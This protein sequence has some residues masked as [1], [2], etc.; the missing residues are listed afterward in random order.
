MSVFPSHPPSQLKYKLAL[1]KL[2]KHHTKRISL[3]RACFMLCCGLSLSLLSTL[4]Y[5]QVKEQSQIKI[6]GGKLIN[7]NNIY[8]TLNFDYPQFIWGING[9]K[10]EQKIES[11]P[12]VAVA[13]VNRK[14]IPPEIVISLQE[15]NPVALASFQGQV[16]FLDSQGEWISLNFYGNLDLDNALPR[17]KVID[18]EL[19]FKKIWSQIYHLISLHPELKVSEVHWHQSGSIYIQTKIGRFF[20][21]SESSRLEEQFQIMSKLINLPQQLASSEISYIDISNPEVNLIQR[22]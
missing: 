11:I 22:Y 14:I 21:G 13:K 20:L 5:W 10:I 9:E 3:W 4:P 18:Y 12:S 16:G 7:K 19:Q 2:Q 15:K 1:V 17:L 6:N 8:R